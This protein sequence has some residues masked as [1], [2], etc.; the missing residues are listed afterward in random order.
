MGDKVVVS[1]QDL[2]GDLTGEALRVAERAVP[3]CFAS[4]GPRQRVR[5]SRRER[6]RLLGLGEAVT[7]IVVLAALAGRSTACSLHSRCRLDDVEVRTWEE[8]QPALVYMVEV[9]DEQLAIII[10]AAVFIAMAFGI[11]NV[12]LMT[13]SSAP[14]RSAS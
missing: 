4:A 11:A 6:R 8:L 7:E 5:A 10:Y 2:A 14:A 9:F 1:V 13:S 12:L 3:D